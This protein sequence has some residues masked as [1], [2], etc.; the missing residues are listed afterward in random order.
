MGVAI[1]LGLAWEV[2]MRTA[3]V[4]LLLI[5][6]AAVV[7]AAARQT[8]VAIPGG[9]GGI[10]FDGLRFA[11]ALARVL[12]P[13]GRTGRLA[14]LDPAT[15]RVAAVAGVGAREQQWVG[16]GDGGTLAGYVEGGVVAPRA[17]RRR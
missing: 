13:A 8:A 2:A 6:A 12:V 5:G 14:L 4:F 9:K 10:G 11:P 16:H 15:R 17:P 7:A 3:R 1:A